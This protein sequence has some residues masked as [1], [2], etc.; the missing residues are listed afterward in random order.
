MLHYSG[1]ARHN[2]G[3]VF[4]INLDRRSWPGRCRSWGG[5]PRQLGA[6]PEAMTEAGGQAR[7]SRTGQKEPSRLCGTMA[8]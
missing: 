2:A 8:D 4:Q 7:L 5:R 1:R 6:V 3:Q